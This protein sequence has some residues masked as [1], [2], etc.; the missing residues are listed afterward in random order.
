MFARYLKSQLVV[1]LFG[2]V[3]GPIFLIV[4][5]ALDPMSRPY[6]AWMFWM[7]LFITAADVLIALALA[8]Y[9]AKSAAK[10]AALEQSGVLALA[11]ITGMGETGTRINDQPLIKLDLHIEGPG[12]TP[13]DTQDR[14]LASVTRMGNFTARKLVVLVDPATNQ[15]QIDWERSALVNGLVPAQFTLADDNKTYDL[16]GQAGPLME[17]LQLLKANG[18]PLN[19]MVDVR[20]NPALRE[21][22]QAVVRRAAAQQSPAAPS[23]AAAPTPVA[24]PAVAPLAPPAPSISQRLQELETLRATGMVSEQE[25]K[26]RRTQIIS[27]I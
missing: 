20:S 9:S 24:A 25:Y 5:F 10:T 1:L 13:F 27:E 22:I 15:Y 16:S 19:R 3:V 18:I 12:I 23:Q 21:Q 2:G 7:G 6:I 8:N 11:Q 17:I 14:V 26:A 4:Y